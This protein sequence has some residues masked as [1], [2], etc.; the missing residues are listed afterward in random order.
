MASTPADQ[1]PEGLPGMAGDLWQLI[2]G[3]LKQETLDPLKGLLRFVAFGLLGSLVLGA[4]LVLLF[5]GALRLLQD[6]TGSTFTGNLSW[7]P[8]LLTVLAC[9]VVVALAIR[10]RSRGQRRE[11]V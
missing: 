1:G 10:A 7:I 4:G 11:G 9:A 5:L 8:Y 6:E 2:I 3:Y